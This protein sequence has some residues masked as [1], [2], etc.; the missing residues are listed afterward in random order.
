MTKDRVKYDRTT[1]VRIGI[2]LFGAVVLSI[3]Y[4]W[5]SFL[6]SFGAEMGQTPKDREFFWQAFGS[7]IGLLVAGTVAV[8]G[9][10]IW[11]GSIHLQRHPPYLFWRFRCWS[12]AL[13]TSLRRRFPKA[14]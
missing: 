4:M 11:R 13:W 12:V 7:I 10:W 1:L 2:V 6:A 5:G 9:Y 8:I 14:V 3:V